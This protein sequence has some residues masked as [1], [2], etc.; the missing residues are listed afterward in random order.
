MF[1]GTTTFI[2]ICFVL[3]ALDSKPSAGGAKSK[4]TIDEHGDRDYSIN[5]EADY[6]YEMERA[7]EEYNREYIND[8][9]GEY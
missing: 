3:I 6:Q 9:Y 1:I 4:S 7:R 8:T 5:N 2:I